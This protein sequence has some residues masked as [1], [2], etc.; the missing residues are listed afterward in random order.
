[1][2]TLAFGFLPTKLTRPRV[3][4]DWVDRPRLIEQLNQSFER[5]RLTLVCGSAGFGKTTLLSSWIESLAA[6][7]RPST[8]GAWVSLDE[9]DSDLVVF[10]RYCVAAIR[11]VFPEACTETVALLQTPQSVSQMPLVIALTNEIERLPARCVL[12]LDDYHTIH[13]TAV[14]DFL[15]ALLRHWPARL[16]LVLISRINPP[17]PLPKLRAG[18]HLT[19]IRTHDLRFRPDE[20]P[21]F[22]TCCGRRSANLRW[23]CSRS[24]WRAGSRGCA[25]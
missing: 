12:V 19:E 5:G 21:N 7:Q 16:H 13:D 25:W 4:A 3:T 10:L 23:R 6:S 20:W 24:G 9:S 11:T 2:T 8:Q 1:M 17:L 14:H 15:G 18:G 22:A